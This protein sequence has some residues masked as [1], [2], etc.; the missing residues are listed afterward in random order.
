MFLRTTPEYWS[1]WLPDSKYRSQLFWGRIKVSDERG[2]SQKVGPRP[3]AR[4]G[5]SIKLK[6]KAQV[7]GASNVSGPARLQIE[8]R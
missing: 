7:K 3:G 5:Q 2:E 8:G 4:G 6:I 1:G